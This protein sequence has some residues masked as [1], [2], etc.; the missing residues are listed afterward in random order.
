MS[1]NKGAT[2]CAIPL[3]YNYELGEFMLRITFIAIS[4]MGNAYS[5]VAVDIPIQAQ[6]HTTD[7][8][9]RA[10]KKLDLRFIQ[11]K[12]IADYKASPPVE[13]LKLT[14]NRLLAQFPN[15]RRDYIALCQMRDAQFAVWES[16]NKNQLPPGPE[17]EMQEQK[18][19]EIGI[20]IGHLTEA[21][22]AAFL[23][24]AAASQLKT[25]G[26]NRFK[27]SDGTVFRI[28]PMG[29]TFDIGYPH[30]DDPKDPN[31]FKISGSQVFGAEFD[32]LKTKFMGLL[33]DLSVDL[34][35]P[36]TYQVSTR[37]LYKFEPNGSA[38]ALAMGGLGLLP[39]EDIG[40]TLAPPE[41]DREYLKRSVLR[42][43]TQDELSSIPSTPTVR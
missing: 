39:F 19:S 6:S 11:K 41:I 16:Y 42:S 36:D 5:K 24:A 43:K 4:L 13:K 8:R 35:N 31:R 23:K 2:V 10:A 34:K 38:T 18:I 33:P 25:A 22:N 15:D 27:S 3:C 7:Q 14:A 1:R 40:Q 12:I 26:E 37:A 32:E 21:M 30:S 9:I 28:L 17:K 29:C 20:A